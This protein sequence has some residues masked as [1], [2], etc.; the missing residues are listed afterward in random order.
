MTNGN[1]NRWL[2]LA[3]MANLSEGINAAAVDGVELVIVKKGEEL[4]VFAGRCLHQEAPMAQGILE[5]NHLVCSKHLWKYSL[6]TGE[7][8][9]E[10]GITLQKFECRQTDQDLE[11]RM[12]QFNELKALYESFDEDDDDEIYVP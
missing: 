3:S 10:P 11:I 4:S 12:D 9:G 1:G 6:Q 5:E 8:E 7:L 2:P